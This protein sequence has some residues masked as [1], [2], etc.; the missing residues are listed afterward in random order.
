MD[1]AQIIRDAYKRA[2]IKNDM[3]ICRETGLHYDKFHKR[4][5]KDIG[6]MRFRE[7]WLLQRHAHFTDEEILEIVREGGNDAGKQTGHLQSAVRSFETDTGVGRYHRVEVHRGK[8]GCS[9][10][11]H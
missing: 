1:K 11:L 7:F 4:R 3:E 6:D 8:L 9:I 5:M 10:C 2:G